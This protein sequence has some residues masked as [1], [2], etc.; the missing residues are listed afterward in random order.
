MGIDK[1]VYGLYNINAKAD[2]ALLYDKG[3]TEKGRL[4]SRS[5]YL[6]IYKANKK[7]AL[8]DRN[9]VMLFLQRYSLSNER[10]RIL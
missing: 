7:A 5:F 8:G 9:G 4:L 6:E 1:R 3:E 10:K 2:R